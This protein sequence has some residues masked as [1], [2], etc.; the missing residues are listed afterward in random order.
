MT[1]FKNTGRAAHTLPKNIK[2]RRAHQRSGPNFN[3][4]I[5]GVKR[6]K[7]SFVKLGA[8]NGRKNNKYG[9]YEKD[10]QTKFSRKKL[11]ANDA[12][13]VY[14]P[15]IVLGYTRSREQQ[16]PNRALVE[17]IGCKTKEDARFYL[18]K[19]V[20]YLTKSGSDES[21]PFRCLVGK[22]CRTHGNSGVVRVKFS[23][24]ITPNAFGKKCRVLLYPAK[25]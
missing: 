15:A 25:N 23:R 13:R 21:K 19:R 14:Q 22:V 17:I 24:N 9:Q 3:S 1:A 2:I 5:A 11:R 6:G 12:S 7:P 4:N 10:G 16:K 18:G 20:L 8:L